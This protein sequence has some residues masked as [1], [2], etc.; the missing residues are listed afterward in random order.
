M[1]TTDAHGK[2]MKQ[3]PQTAC[4]LSGREWPHLSSHFGGSSEQWK[5]RAFWS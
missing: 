4:I 2:K 5:E 1:N 3:K